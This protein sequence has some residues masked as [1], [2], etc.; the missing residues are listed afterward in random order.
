MIERRKNDILA[1]VLLLGFAFFINRGIEI[2][3]LYM[4]D[5]YLWSCFG[6]QSW[7]EYIFP[8]GSTRFRFIY[9]L[10]SYLLMAVI[11]THVTW[12]VPINIILNGLVAVTV[13]A[14]AKRFSRSWGIG[15]LTGIMYLLSRMS[16]Y[17][18]G[19]VY[20]LMETLALWA[21][22]GILFLLYEYIND[23]KRG[24]LCFAIAN[25]L[26]FIVCFTHE[27]YMLLL[28]V[29]LMA[30]AVKSRK[31]ILFWLI[32]VLNFAAVM[33]IRFFTI[34]T[35][36]PAGTGGTDV[37]ETFSFFQA[38]I[39]AVSQVAYIFGV[40]AGPEHLNGIA[41]ANVPYKIKFMVWGTDI[42]I[43]LFVILFI[44]TIIRKK[45]RRK[46]GLIN[47]LLFLL[48]IAM[49]IG[50]SSVTVRLEMR[51][52][53]VSYTAAL[54]YLSYL[55]GILTE[56]RE[57]AKLVK[58]LVP[59]G[60]LFL[61][62]AIL[63]V[64]VEMFY[65]TKFPDIYLFPNQQRYN[66]LAEETYYKYGDAFWGK[67]IYIVN[68]QYEISDFTARTFFKVYDE[69]KPPQGATVKFVDTV[70]D[71]GPVNDS[72]IVLK[73][74]PQFNSFTDITDFLKNQQCERILGY[75]DDGWMDE[76]GH[77]RIMT[78]AGGNINITCYYPGEIK[79]GQQTSIS[80]NDQEPMIIPITQDL[81]TTLIE[82]QPYQIVDLKF[83]NNFYVEDA[84]EQRGEK[85][86]SMVVTFD[87]E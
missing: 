59:Y 26:Y 20:G 61:C 43:F 22:V 39:Y 52:I 84:Q 30:V 68:D 78:G 6:E 41:W 65:R 85:H 70:R 48:F 73:E 27:R 33:A 60:A 18:I 3:G 66:S 49:C 69:E 77:V 13:Y 34:G 54:L 24:T 86:M 4:D 32:P 47:S 80:V 55:Y 75:Y 58:I 8:M 14:A 38:I 1:I 15:L 19:Q 64:P 35:L 11:G 74:E 44:V 79:E 25:L 81:T 21:A 5:L 45:D 67:T 46:K 42:I 72:M 9:Y 87:V 12:F 7:K 36:A 10:A 40:N 56:G 82:A 37:V 29:L 23:N 71:I 53:Y 62:Y 16:Y 17:Q 63:T 51:W 2:K 28:P 76:S 83:E 57:E 31:K 50:S